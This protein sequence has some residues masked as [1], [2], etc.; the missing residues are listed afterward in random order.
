MND[1]GFN[2]MQNYQ[3]KLLVAHP[4][5]KDGAFARSVVYLYQHSVNG[6]IGLVLNR[7]TACR[8]DRFLL[9]KGYNFSGLE[10]FY[11][12]GPVNEKAIVMLHDN[13]WYS[14]S[15]MQ[16]GNGLAVSSDLTMFEKLSTGN[17]PKDWR[18][19]TGVSA[20]AP[21]QLQ[22]EVSAPNGWQIAAPDGSFVFEQDG[23]RQW[24]TAIQLCSQQLIDQYI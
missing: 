4:N 23:E 9:E 5:L 16:V 24:N 10:V 21:G 12:G 7:A 17:M 13:D 20:W 19:F 8:V 1:I 6:D 18:M 11:K 15:T 2:I 3:G 22:V 14:S